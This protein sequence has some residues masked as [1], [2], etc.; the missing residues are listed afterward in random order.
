MQSEKI[1]ILKGNL[2]FTPTPETFV[3]FSNGYL[4]INQGVIQELCETLPEKYA[5]CRVQDYG[6]G[7]IIPGF[8]DLHTHASQ[9]NQ[10]GLGLDLQLL[11]WLNQY[12]FKEESHFNEVAYAKEVYEKFAAEIV[13]QGTTRVSVFATIHK[14]SSQ[15]LFDILVNK[16]IGAY[17]GK[18]NMDCNCPAFLREETGQSLAD[19]EELI[20]RWGGNR[21]V[22]PIITPRFAITSTKELLEGLGKLAIQ[23]NLPV[24]SHLSENQD[25]VKMVNRLFPEQREY[26][27]VYDHY[28][29]FGQTPT[30]M[31]HCIHLSNDTVAAMKNNHVVAVHCP[32]SNLNLASGIMPARKLVKAGIA[33]GL[34]SDIGAGQD[35]F[36]PRTMVRA[37]QMSKAIYSADPQQKPLTL[38]EAFYMGTK[39]GGKFFGKVG[40]FEPGYEFDG[41]VISDEQ[42]QGEER[43]IMERLERFIYT[44]D[45]SN[46]V[47]RYVAGREIK[48]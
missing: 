6:D 30:L 7:L 36:M 14:D 27:N 12:T 4:V 1:L 28:Q 46:I 48:Y 16:G 44:G 32:D 9:F 31:A 22:K 47:A 5:S 29:L 17:V 13:K 37:I 26:H 33:I 45:H 10:R 25:E 38:S 2:I 24:Q 34:G 42:E 39:G 20:Q 19:T 43:S 3:V 21:L 15:A 40:S 23:Y 18:V 8:V 41:L 35:L 11:E